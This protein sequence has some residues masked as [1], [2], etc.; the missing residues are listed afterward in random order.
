MATALSTAQNLVG[1]RWI[2]PAATLPVCDPQDGSVISRVPDG[3][4]EMMAAAIEGAMAGAAVAEKLSVHQ[5]LTMLRRAAELVEAR[6]E[7]FAYTLACESSKTIR[8]ARAE[9]RRAVDTLRLSSEE[10][11]RITGETIAFDRRP[12]AEQRSGFY[13]R[14]PVGVVAAITPFND[15]LNLVAHKLGPALAAGN[16]VVLKPA[17]LAPL[18]ALRLVETL[19]EAGVPPEVLAVVTGSG[20]RLGGQLVS[21]PGVGLVS[22]TGGLETGRRIARQAGLKKLSMELGA[23]SPVLVLDD[24]DLDLAADAAVS[25]A[26]SNAGQ[27]C[28]GVQRVFVHRRVLDRFVARMVE[29]TRALRVGS[30]LAEDTD[31][32]PLI[33]EREAVRVEQ[34][35]REAVAE[36]AEVLAGGARRGAYYDPTV[37]IG[38][39][40]AS[41]VCRDEVYGP[42]VGV[43]SVQDVDEAIAR[44]NEVDYGLQAGVFTRDLGRAFRC[45]RGLRVGGV[46]INDSSDFRV[47]QMP[48][49]G[50]KGSGL[51]REGVHFAAQSMTETKVVCFNLTESAPPGEMA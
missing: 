47:D 32:G 49:G 38:A 42:V 45:I 25:G 11:A 34:W 7:T 28:L 3:T 41:R 12:G 50:F 43:Y 26:F 13:E 29:R 2:A 18:S 30:K 40:A 1:G 27:N 35:V 16:A 22:F 44:A 6:S 33:A 39:P 15:P 46:M 14:V 51:G 5:R 37:L 23:N 8:E 31:M 9:V 48:F 17:S 20:S 36:G 10:S 19:L 24:A 4:D 21:H